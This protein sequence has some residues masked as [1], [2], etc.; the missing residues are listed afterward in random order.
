[1]KMEAYSQTKNGTKPEIAGN[2]VRNEGRY[3]NKIQ[4]TTVGSTSQNNNKAEL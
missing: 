2:N 3:Q 4:I 1:M